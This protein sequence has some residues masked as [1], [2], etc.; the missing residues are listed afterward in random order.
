MDLKDLVAQFG[1]PQK[2]YG[3]C[4]QMASPRVLNEDG[5]LIMGMV[6][7]AGYVSRIIAYSRALDLAAFKSFVSTSL[8]PSMEVQ[9]EDLRT[10]T[11]FAWDL[12]L[13]EGSAEALKAAYW[14]QNYRGNKKSD[15]D[16]PGL[17]M[18]S[19]CGSLFVQ[20]V[21]NRSVLCK[22]CAPN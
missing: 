8:G 3:H 16:R 18:C 6:C 10:A 15:P 19:S 20:P 22:N 14:T 4:D 13:P 17:F 7:H 9:D 1:E 11:R 5:M 21:S 12:G 2:C